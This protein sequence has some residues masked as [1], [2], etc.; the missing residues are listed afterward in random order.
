MCPF[1]FFAVF[2][3]VSQWDSVS[4]PSWSTVMGGWI[5]QSVLT[6]WSLVGLQQSCKTK[7]EKDMRGKKECLFRILLFFFISV[8][9]T[10]FERWLKSHSETRN[11]H[12]SWGTQLFFSRLA[13]EFL[14][15]SSSFLTSTY[16]PVHHMSPHL[17]GD[18]EVFRWPG[19]TLT[20]LKSSSGGGQWYTRCSRNTCLACGFFNWLCHSCF[21]SVNQKKSD[22]LAVLWRERKETRVRE[23]SMGSHR[24]GERGGE[25]CEV[26]GKGLPELRVWQVGA[27]QKPCV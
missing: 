3:A 5:F 10:A 7:S 20:M 26:A 11:Q 17:P 12:V 27:D 14:Y 18:S 23:K 1:L 9:L 6:F 24:R 19:C 16:R 13:P 2:Y 25:G 15:S 21:A 4:V 22:M 8:V